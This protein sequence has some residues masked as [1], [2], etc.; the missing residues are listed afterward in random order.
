MCNGCP[1]LKWKQFVFNA[2]I[3]VQS[4]DILL[5][6]YNPIFHPYFRPIAALHIFTGLWPDMD[7]GR[8]IQAGSVE[9]NMKSGFNVNTDT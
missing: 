9:L 7:N 3:D 6:K 5:S 4:V 2:D 1:S 8:A